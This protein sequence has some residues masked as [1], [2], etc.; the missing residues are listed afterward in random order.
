MPLQQE[1]K[2]ANVKN[3]VLMDHVHVK[4]MFF[5]A[6]NVVVRIVITDQ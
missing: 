5:V 1:L 2:I 3:S 6:Q 4:V